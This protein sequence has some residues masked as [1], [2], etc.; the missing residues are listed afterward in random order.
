MVIAGPEYEF[1]YAG[2]G[3]NGRVNDSDIWNKVSLLQEIQDGSVNLS[4]DE[5][6]SNGEFNPYIFLVDDAFALKIFMMKPFP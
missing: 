4:D 6:L 1:L 3:S 2:V 5:K